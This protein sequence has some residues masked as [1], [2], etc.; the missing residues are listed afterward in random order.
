MKLRDVVQVKVSPIWGESFINMEAYVVPEISSIPNTHVELVKSDYPHL[1]GLW[2][3]DVSKERDEMVIDVLIG[4]DYLW[5][6][7]KGCTIRG[8]FDEPVAVETELGWVLSGPMKGQDTCSDVHFTQVNFIASSVEEQESLEDVQRLWDLETLGIREITD[9]VHESFENSISFNGTRYSVR[10]PWKEG[11][12]ELPSNYGTSLHRLKTQM[13]RLEKD[14]EI[15]KEYGNII[16]DQ[17]RVGVIEKVAELEK[18]PRIH[19]LPHQ[20]VVRQESATTKV[21]VVYD[22]S[23]KESKSVACLN[24]CLHVGPPLTPLLY[25]ILLRFRENRVVLVG[26]IEKAFLNVEVDPEDRDCL[27]FLWVEK[28]PDLSQVVVYRFCRVVFGLNASPFLLNATL[29]HHVKRYEISDPRF[30]AKLLDSFYVDDFVGGGATAQESMELYQKTQSRMAEGGF[31]L[32]KWLTND[33]GP[34]WQLKPRLVIN[35][36]W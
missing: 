16:Q 24:D 26:D 20:A 15:L 35:K 33:S 3:S 22:A 23:S 29:R 1:K 17:L 6:F 14:P 21:R 11:H 18:A 32:R 27:R 9:Q 30:V 2:F 19:Y 31:K 7:Q 34:K 36:M 5:Q 25:N 4:A 10:L 12:P 28:P 13:R 8:K